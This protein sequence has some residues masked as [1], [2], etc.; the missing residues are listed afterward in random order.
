MLASMGKGKVIV[1]HGGTEELRC[2]L[3]AVGRDNLD[4]GKGFYVTDIKSQAEDWAVRKAAVR[5]A[6]PVLNQYLLD[7][8]AMEGFSYKRFVTYNEEWLDFIIANRNGENPARFYDIIEGGV[9]N[10][11][12]IDSI[13]A[14]MAGLMPK[15]MCLGRL[16][17]H[18]PNNQ[19]CIISQD[20]CD[21]CLHFV[22]ST[23]IG[24]YAE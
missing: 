21:R 23:R 7:F 2:P 12:V 14:Y 5:R 13:E 3:T 17:E 24:K 10:D 9:A 4:F 11:R 20:L 6:A 16:S 22:E 19:I 1:Y 18:R 15:A 8:D